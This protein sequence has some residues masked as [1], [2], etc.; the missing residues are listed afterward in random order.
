MDVA[1][2]KAVA[3]FESG[4]MKGNQVKA[5][6]INFLCEQHIREAFLG[7]LHGGSGAAFLL[8]F[9]GFQFFTKETF[10]ITLHGR[11]ALVHTKFSGHP[12]P[13]GIKPA[14]KNTC[15]KGMEQE[16]Q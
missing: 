16:N 10:T 4:I 5:V 2:E 8:F 12:L 14:G 7:L 1:V 13:V 3:D 11:P 15:M 9:R 6:F